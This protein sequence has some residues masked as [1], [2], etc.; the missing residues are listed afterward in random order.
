MLPGNPVLSTSSTSPGF[1]HSRQRIW[2]DLAVGVFLLS[3]LGFGSVGIYHLNED[4]RELQ[5]SSELAM[6]GQELSRS[7]GCIA[8]HTVD[9]SLGVGPSWQG[10]WGETRMLANG[11]EV[12]VDEAYFRRSLREP[13]RDLVAGY[14]NV[15][16]RYFLDDEEIQ[17]LMAFAQSLAS[18]P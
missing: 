3:L 5:L 10:M 4:A 2:L 14:P 13:E 16:L 7:L 1:L 11:N 6:R 18:T 17:A 15:M 8:C 12:L 9:G